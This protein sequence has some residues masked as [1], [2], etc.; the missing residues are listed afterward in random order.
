MRSGE[1]PLEALCLLYGRSDTDSAILDP[2]KEPLVGKFCS[3]HYKLCEHSQPSEPFN[4]V[5]RHRHTR[6][7]GER[8][9]KL[10]RRRWEGIKGKGRGEGNLGRMERK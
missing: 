7:F 2:V 9:C 4:M 3:R 1:G 8:R 6:P 10:E 5:T